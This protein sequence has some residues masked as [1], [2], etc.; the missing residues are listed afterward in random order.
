M[1]DRPRSRSF[2]VTRSTQTHK[3]LNSLYRDEPKTITFKAELSDAKDGCDAIAGSD[4]I[5]AAGVTSPEEY[6]GLQFID[7]NLDDQVSNS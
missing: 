5:G 2:S 4:A 6:D 1:V 3:D 7:D